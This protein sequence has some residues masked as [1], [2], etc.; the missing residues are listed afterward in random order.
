MSSDIPRKEKEDAFA[1]IAIAIILIL[2]AWGNA[3]AMMIGSVVA[4]V[5]MLVVCEG[6]L[7]RGAALPVVVA[8]SVAV[9]LA[10]AFLVGWKL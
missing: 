1:A 7:F 5:M 10:I 3:I 6:R 2:T 8:I 9:I 4:L